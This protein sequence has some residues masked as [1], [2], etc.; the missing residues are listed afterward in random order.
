MYMVKESRGDFVIYHLQGTATASG[1]TKKVLK[2]Y[3]W[4][5]K[6]TAESAAKRMAK[7]CNNSNIKFEAVDPEELGM[8]I[9]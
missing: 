8:E 1:S 5:K 4:A 9:V 3:L 7:N 6:S 2:A